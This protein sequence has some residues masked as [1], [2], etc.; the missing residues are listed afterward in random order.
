MDVISTN[1]TFPV[2][3]SKGTIILSQATPSNTSKS[4][5]IQHLP[6]K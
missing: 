1:I 4:N 5:Q 3:I 2:A 6:P